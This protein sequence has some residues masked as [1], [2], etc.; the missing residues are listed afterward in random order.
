MAR[1][2][3]AGALA[4]QAVRVGCSTERGVCRLRKVVELE[5]T[6]ALRLAHT[7]MAGEGEF[8]RLQRAAV[9][10]RLLFEAVDSGS[11][12]G[13]Q[14]REGLGE[15]HVR[16]CGPIAASGM[17]GLPNICISA[18]QQPWRSQTR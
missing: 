8:V 2:E 15:V 9:S 14:G 4:K 17:L 6:D 10:E 3:P 11:G 7:G 5:Q 18:W 12:G 1:G 13:E 16:R